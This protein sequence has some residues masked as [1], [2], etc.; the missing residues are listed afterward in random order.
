MWR[1]HPQPRN[2]FQ[3]E[4]S[5]FF[6]GEVAAWLAW[7]T[8]RTARGAAARLMLRTLP[9]EMRGALGIPP[10]RKPMSVLLGSMTVANLRS[11]CDT[12]DPEAGGGSEVSRATGR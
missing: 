8:S 5:T 6:T 11:T 7:R 2:R 4:D 3:N 10:M 12:D 9:D 1:R